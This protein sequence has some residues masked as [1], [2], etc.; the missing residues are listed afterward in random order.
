MAKLRNRVFSSTAL[1]HKLWTLFGRGNTVLEMY[2]S[3]L[4]VGIEISGQAVTLSDMLT[5]WVGILMLVC[6]KDLVVVS[7]VTCEYVIYSSLSNFSGHYLVACLI[8]LS[9]G[10]P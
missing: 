5:E 9:I 7:Y 4:F 8:Y 3:I 1:F 10:T 2:L 6:Q